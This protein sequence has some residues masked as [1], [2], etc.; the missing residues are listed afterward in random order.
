MTNFAKKKQNKQTSKKKRSS[1]YREFAYYRKFE[2]S[3]F[4]REMSLRE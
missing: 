1:V 4:A 2:L 3:Y